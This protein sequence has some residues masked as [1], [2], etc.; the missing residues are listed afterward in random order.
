MRQPKKIESWQEA[1]K[2][3][4][5]CPICGANYEIEKAKLFSKNEAANLIHIPC[6]ECNSYFVAMI[7]V[8]GHGLSSVG[9]VTDLSFDDITRL[10][11]IDPIT[12]NEMITGYETINNQYFLHSLILNG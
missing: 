8:V 1:L 11:K 6:S 12:T 4:N 5:R 2:F 7:L 3:I 10:H 9:M